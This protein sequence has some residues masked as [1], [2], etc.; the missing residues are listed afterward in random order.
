MRK[1]IFALRRTNHTLL[2]MVPKEPERPEPQAE[3][4]ASAR[5]ELPKA[6]VLLVR[7]KPKVIDGPFAEAKE[8]I[9]G[10]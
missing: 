4:V 5:E 3:P 9:G 2:V 7:R 1:W 10:S 8:V 6:A